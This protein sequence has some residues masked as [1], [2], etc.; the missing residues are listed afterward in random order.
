MKQFLKLTLFTIALL[1]GTST[2]A[3]AQQKSKTKAKTSKTTKKKVTKKATTTKKVATS[4][5]PSTTTKKKVTSKSTKAV[6]PKTT[7]TKKTTTAKKT[8][9]TKKTSTAKKVYN[10]PNKSKDKSIGKDAKGR[11]IY[12]GP[13]GGKYYINSKGK[14]LKVIRPHQIPKQLWFVVLCKLKT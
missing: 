13:K 1:I 7:A 10:K 11:I 3:F 2:T 14:K 8:T 9:S 6:K 12:Q 4:K 5:K